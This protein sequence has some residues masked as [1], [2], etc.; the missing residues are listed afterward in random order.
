MPTDPPL[1]DQDLYHDRH[2]VSRRLLV[3]PVRTHEE[4]V[5]SARSE[6]ERWRLGG[7]TVES[8]GGT[9]SRLSPGSSFGRYVVESRLARGGMG[10][11][12][13][14]TARGPGGFQK[15][16]VIKTVLPDLMEKPAY[17]QMLVREASLAARLDHP[18]IVHVFDLGCVGGMYYIA[19]EYLSGRTLAQML[20]RS[21]DLGQ[22]LP[23]RVLLTMVAI[24]CDGLQYAHDYAAEDGRPLGLLHRDISPS[25]I[26]LTFAGRIALLDFG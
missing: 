6:R 7:R 22:R 2:S 4:F 5:D 18:N 19:M 24:A 23:L 15:R 8:T 10:E 20:R 1:L 16:V 9:E 26:M 12:W 14:A 17:V 13:L 25:N 3:V 21:H 11:V